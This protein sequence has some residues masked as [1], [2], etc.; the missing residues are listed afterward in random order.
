MNSA[1]VAVTKQVKP[2]ESML[3]AAMRVNVLSPVMVVVVG[4][5]VLAVNRKQH[6]RGRFGQTTESYRGPRQWHDARWIF[7]ELGRSNDLFS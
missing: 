3:Q 7:S 6:V 5:E 1:L 4:V 2:E